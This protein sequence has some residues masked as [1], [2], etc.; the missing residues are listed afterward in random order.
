MSVF[1]ANDITS[2]AFVIFQCQLWPQGCS[3]YCSWSLLSTA[4]MKDVYQNEED[5]QALFPSVLIHFPK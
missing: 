1:I 3:G 5:I 2:L 4:F